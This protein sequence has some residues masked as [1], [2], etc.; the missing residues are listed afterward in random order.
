MRKLAIVV[1]A[2]CLGACAPS[3]VLMAHSF[4]STNKVVETV[5]EPSG[6][7][8]GT[9]KDKKRLFNVMLRVCDQGADPTPARCRDSV[10]LNDVDPDSL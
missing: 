1:S 10:L 5:I 7:T 2:L 4:A 3:K 6:A 9:D 8:V